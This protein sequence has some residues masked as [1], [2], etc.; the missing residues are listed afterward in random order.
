MQSDLELL[1]RRAVC[2]AFGG[3]HPATLYRHV[4]SG[5]VPR[6]VKVGSL[7]RWLRHEVEA[8]LQRM[9]EGRAAR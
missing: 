9:V 8:S 4:R 7:S 3:I 2:A 1:D 5:T 6:P